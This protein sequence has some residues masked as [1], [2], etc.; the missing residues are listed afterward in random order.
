MCVSS[1]VLKEIGNVKV[2]VKEIDRQGRPLKEVPYCLKRP[3]TLV[4]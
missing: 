2:V 3:V 4:N 1:A